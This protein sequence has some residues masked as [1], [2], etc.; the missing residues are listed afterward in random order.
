MVV[1]EVQHPSGAQWTRYFTD[2]DEALLYIYHVTQ[3]RGLSASI[4]TDI[5]M[6]KE[7][8]RGERIRDAQER[9]RIQQKEY[10]DAMAAYL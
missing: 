7:P 10:E 9:A 5:P 4:R 1:V 6:V 2:P 8:T 3:G